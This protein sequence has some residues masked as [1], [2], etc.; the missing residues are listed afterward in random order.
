MDAVAAL[1]LLADADL[2]VDGVLG[3]GG[4]PGLDS[5][6]AAFADACR[7]TRAVVVAV[8]LPS[9]LD[10][11]AATA[12]ESFTADITVTFGA[13]KLCHIAE[14]NHGAAFYELLDRVLPDWQHRNQRLERIMA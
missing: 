2:V 11:D 10:A 8:D 1:E 13:R 3:I 7:D 5:A 4:R 12:S 6:V 14:P 9:G